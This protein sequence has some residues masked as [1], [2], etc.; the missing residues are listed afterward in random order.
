ME[1]LNVL[2]HS[3]PVVVGIALV[4]LA[5]D[6]EPKAHKVSLITGIVLIVLGLLI[7]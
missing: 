2:I 3:V 6:G 7:R 5:L 1:I 4:A